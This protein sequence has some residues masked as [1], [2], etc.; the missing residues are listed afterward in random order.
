MPSTQGARIG[1]VAGAASGLAIGLGLWPRL[2]LDA[3]NLIFLS[4]ATAVGGWTGGWAPVLGHTSLDD[5]ESTKVRGG[6]LA[7]AGGA[8]LLAT[9]LVPRLHADRDVVGDALLLDAIFTGAGAGAGGL[10]SRRADAPVWG[11]LGAGTA[12]LLLGGVLHTSID[13]EESSGLVTFAGIEGVWAGAGCPTCC[14]PPRRSP[15][16]TTSLAW[17]PVASVP[18]VCR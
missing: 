16:R 17:P 7:G 9:A 4:A 2:E 10:A 6:L 14:A 15:A 18:R 1:V 5:V 12:G 11:M 13:L 3:D 8:S